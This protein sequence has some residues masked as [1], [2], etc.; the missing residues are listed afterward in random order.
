MVEAWCLNRH[1]IVVFQ[2]EA[3]AAY[4]GKNFPVIGKQVIN[5]DPVEGV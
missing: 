2:I 1:G 5:R 3:N 4:L